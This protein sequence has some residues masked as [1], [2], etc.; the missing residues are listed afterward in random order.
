MGTRKDLFTPVWILCIKILS[1]E[2][3]FLPYPGICNTIQYNC[4][5]NK[6]KTDSESQKKISAS[7]K[8][9]NFGLVLIVVAQVTNDYFFNITKAKYIDS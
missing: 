7:S 6:Q 1:G 3:D 8:T 5:Y 2:F 4:P 9:S